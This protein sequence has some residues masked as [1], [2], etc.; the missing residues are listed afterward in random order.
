MGP[1][2]VH[3]CFEFLTRSGILQATLCFTRGILTCLLLGVP[4][5]WH[6]IVTR[7]GGASFVK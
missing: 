3:L 2:V 5:V 1:Q 6:G 4:W 7:K